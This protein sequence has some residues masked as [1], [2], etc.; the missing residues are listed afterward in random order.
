MLCSKHGDNQ[1]TGDCGILGYLVF[2]PID[3]R[4]AYVSATGPSCRGFH[5]K[6]H[7]QT[8]YDRPKYPRLGEHIL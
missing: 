7:R 1:E 3:G 6:H 4:F 2:L 5:N 8:P